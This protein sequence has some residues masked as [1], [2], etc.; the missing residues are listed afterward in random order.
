MIDIFVSQLEISDASGYGKVG[1]IYSAWV[2]LFAT[3]EGNI[4]WG[5]NWA[6]AWSPRSRCKHH[7]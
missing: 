3:K 7:L 1:E 5:L 6:Y 2:P 4:E